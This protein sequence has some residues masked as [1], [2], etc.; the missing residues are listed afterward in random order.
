MPTPILAV[1]FDHD[2]TLVDSEP[3]HFR[4]W[5]DVLAPHGVTFTEEDYKARHAG[6]PT[7]ANAQEL[8]S[9]HALAVGADALAARKHDAMSEFVTREAFPLMPQVREAVAS[10]H[11]HGLRLAVVTGAVQLSVAATL[12][13]HA[14]ESWFELVVSAEDVVHNKPAP[15][16]YLL[17]A[18]RLGLSPAQCV[19]IE[20]TQAG[21]TSAV[22]AGMAC[23]AVPHALSRDQDFSRASAVVDSLAEAVAW[24]EA[25]AAPR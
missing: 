1:C 22:S 23:V 2:G 21:V 14:L 7:A 10:L 17:A 24:I 12:R 19:A 11:A 4:L 20:D 9:R 18:Q 3:I 25:R 8:A 13:E 16:C 5:R 15:D 6:V